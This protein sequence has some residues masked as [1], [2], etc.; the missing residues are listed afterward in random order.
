[1]R[2]KNSLSKPVCQ[3]GNPLGYGNCD[4]GLPCA[5]P[6]HEYQ[7]TPSGEKVCCETEGTTFKEDCFTY[8]LILIVLSSVF[9]AAMVS[10]KNLH[11]SNCA[12]QVLFF[13]S[14]S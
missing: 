5:K 7:T 6:D 12:S 8:L 14:F 4:E 3:V 2:E 1:M 9:P 13:L 10:N 11:L